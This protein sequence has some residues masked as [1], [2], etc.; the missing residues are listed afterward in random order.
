M[1]AATRYQ[2]ARMAAIPGVDAP[3]GQNRNV[4]RRADQLSTHRCDDSITVSHRVGG[5]A[6][7]LY[8]QTG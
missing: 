2:Q 8:E 5:A 1:G 6:P 7:D 3:D 4:A